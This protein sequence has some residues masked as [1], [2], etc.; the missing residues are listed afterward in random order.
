MN[1]SAAI[2]A[3]RWLVRDTFRQALATRLFWLMLAVSG[4]CIVFCLGVS[5]EGGELRRDPHT[6]EV[7]DSAG[8]TRNEPGFQPG[9][10]TLLFGAVPVEFSNDRVTEIRFLEGVLAL[11]V[12]GAAGLLLALLWTAG[13]LPEFLQPGAA[14]VLLAK[15]VP[16]WSLLVGKYLGVVAFVAFQAAVFFGGTWLALGLRTGVWLP[17]Y[18]LGCPLLVLHFA[19]LYSFSVLLAVCTRS[20]VACIFGSVLFWFLC[21]GANYGRHAA[22]AHPYLVPGSAPRP[23]S[24]RVLVEAG[25][26]ALPKPADMDILLN[27][28]LQAQDLFATLPEFE[29]VR[30]KGAFD[31]ELSLLTS[32]LFA[33][34]MLAVASRQLALTDY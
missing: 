15:P 4:L 22:V 32:F 19:A 29:K 1:L 7:L 6:G 14:A 30:E 17:H 11:R 26:W 13:F 20:T 28:A 25:Y 24:F 3:V 5:I 9:R 12:A 10:M 16:R 2:Y 34:A 21:Y 31:P 18:L 8:R 23:A 33:V 27:Q